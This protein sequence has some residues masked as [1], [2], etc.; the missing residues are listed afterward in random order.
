MGEL[1]RRHSASAPAMNEQTRQPLAPIRMEMPFRPVV[2]SPSAKLTICDDG[3]STGELIR[4]RSERFI[5][6]RTEGDLQLPNDEQVSSRHVSLTQQVVGNKTR[7]VVTD[8]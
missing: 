7:W 8:L 2:R 5:I 6:G 3:E 4:L 1:K